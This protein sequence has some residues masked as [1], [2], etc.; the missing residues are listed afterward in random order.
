[1]DQLIFEQKS[2]VFY[3]YIIRDEN[4]EFVGRIN[5]QILE[6]ENS[7]KADLGY[8]VD[9]EK[10][11]KGFANQAISLV[12]KEAFEKLKVSE[13]TAGTSRDNIASQRV[14]EKNG[15]Q[16]IGEEKKVMKVNNEWCAVLHVYD[17]KD[18][19]KYRK[20]TY[21]NCKKRKDGWIKTNKAG[22]YYED[23]DST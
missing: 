23:I 17:V 1:M 2:G 16:K 4:D 22:D 20:F 18:T 3:M 5:L 9:F 7:L 11:G 14:L 10:Q 6:T 15:F 13:V 21:G 12:L 19:R 8:R